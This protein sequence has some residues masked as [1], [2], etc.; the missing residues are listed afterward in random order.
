MEKIEGER[1]MWRLGG[2]DIRG[3]NGRKGEGRERR[4]IYKGKGEYRDEVGRVG[5]N[6]ATWA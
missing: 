4:P 1:R 6:V 5:W 2:W 3:T